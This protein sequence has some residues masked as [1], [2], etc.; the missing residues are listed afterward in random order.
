LTTSAKAYTPSDSVPLNLA[1]G[2]Y[3]VLWYYYDKTVPTIS[4]YLS[5]TP[6]VLHK[7]NETNLIT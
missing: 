2:T 5:K 3:Q 4:I 7:R 6:F 1:M